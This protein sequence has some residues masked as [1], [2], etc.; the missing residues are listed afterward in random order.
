ENEI[1]S[2]FRRDLREAAVPLAVEVPGVGQPILGLLIRAE[3]TLERNRR[4]GR[5]AIGWATSA[6]GKNRGRGANEQEQTFHHKVNLPGSIARYPNISI[7][8]KKHKRH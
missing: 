6:L 3:N 5:F 7:S 4:H 8:D 1:C 2:V